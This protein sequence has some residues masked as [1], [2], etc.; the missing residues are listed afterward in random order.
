M[1]ETKAE[2]TA[3]PLLLGP[4]TD[5]DRLRRGPLFP[6]RRLTGFWRRPP[7][8]LVLGAMKSG[9]STLL[10][11]LM[12]HPGVNG[13]LRKEVHFFSH[14]VPVAG[15]GRDWYRAHF[16]LR[17]PFASANL[18]GEA[19]PDYLY[20]PDAPARIRAALPNVRL[21]AI[22]REPAERAVSHYHHEVRMGRET[23]PL[24]EALAMEERRL[25]HAATLGAAG[26]ETLAHACY[27]RRGV[28]ADQIARVH[29]LFGPERLLVLGTGALKRD[30]EGTLARAFA[31]L[32]LPP[33]ALDAAVVRNE[34][35]RPPT[36]PAVL[37]ELRAWFA[38]HD[39]RLAR[40]LGGLPEW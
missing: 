12:R 2:R 37:K 24:E 30:P 21:L 36:P 28:Y 11:H 14:A 6:L 4:R 29:A 5:D 16:P 18:T 13:P 15:H 31:H 17:P 1:T 10:H 8:F 19:T 35:G 39:E 32:G 40:I 22:L 33:I 38:P 20:D 7:D 23:L 27:R 34:G 25:A 3:D 26:R 9:T